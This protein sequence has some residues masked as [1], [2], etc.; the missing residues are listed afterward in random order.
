MIEKDKKTKNVRHGM[1]MNEKGK[2]K[3]AIN[4]MTKIR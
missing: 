1:K 4:E 2:K 3:N